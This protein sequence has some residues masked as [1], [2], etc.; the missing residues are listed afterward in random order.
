MIEE[1]RKAELQAAVKAYWLEYY[2]RDFD[3][4]M[5]EA[6][7]YGLFE[8][9]MLAREA[10]GIYAGAREDELTEAEYTWLMET[11]AGL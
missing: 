10:A 4:E 1:A 11:Y 2:G 6:K 5:E 8:A 7:E 9:G 3:E